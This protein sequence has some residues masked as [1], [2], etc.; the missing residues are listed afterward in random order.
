MS[1]KIDKYKYRCINTPAC[2]VERGLLLLNRSTEALI[3]K[4]SQLASSRDD[5]GC[6]ENQGFLDAALRSLCLRRC[7]YREHSS[8]ESSR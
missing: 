1:E 6:P 4:Q 2:V 8:H 5:A 7:L 3:S